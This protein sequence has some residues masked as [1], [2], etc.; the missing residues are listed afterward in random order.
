MLQAIIQ[1]RIGGGVVQED[2]REEVLDLQDA[3]S[4][5][6]CLNPPPD[7]QQRIADLVEIPGSTARAETFKAET[8]ELSEVLE[9]T[10]DW[11]WSLLLELPLKEVAAQF[12]LPWQELDGH[13]LLH[14]LIQHGACLR[15]LRQLKRVGRERTRC[16]GQ[17]PK[18]LSHMVY[19]TAI[20][21]AMVF[22]NQLISKTDP[23]NTRRKLRRALERE[24]IEV[25]TKSLL[26]SALSAPIVEKN[27]ETSAE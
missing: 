23:E 11:Q 5:R 18:E 16:P 26:R 17:L 9:L 19:L 4:G 1:D 27:A 12:E 24:W 22:H 7:L 15:V 2:V 14:D 20:A 3:L 10:L 21:A 13:L 8:K 6:V 25:K